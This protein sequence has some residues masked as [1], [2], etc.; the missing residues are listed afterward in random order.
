LELSQAAE[1][2]TWESPS[3]HLSAESEEKRMAAAMA[4]PRFA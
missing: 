1:I 2:E 4:V 3:L